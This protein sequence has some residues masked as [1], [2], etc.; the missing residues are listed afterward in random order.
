MTMVCGVQVAASCERTRL[1]AG[2]SSKMAA[3]LKLHA[4]IAMNT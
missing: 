3:A 1:D 2:L 4:V